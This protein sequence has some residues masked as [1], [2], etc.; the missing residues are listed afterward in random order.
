VEPP[1]PRP[2]RALPK[3]IGR[4]RVVGRLGKGAMAIVYR[5]YDDVMERPVAI[6]VMMADLQDDPE[7]SARFYREAHAAGQLMHRNIITIFDMGED[8]GRPYIV[9]ELLEGQTLGEYVERSDG[10]LLEDK[11][12]L[13]AQVFEGLRPA[14]SK[15]IFHRD[16]KPGNLLVREDGSLKIVD[17][18]IARLMTSSMTVSGLIVG[19]PDYMSPEQACGR[20]VD[21]RSDIFS[22]GAVFYYM[23]TRRKPFAASDLPAVLVKV[24]NEQPLPIRDS[25][26]PPALAKVVMKALEK[27]PAA[28]YQDAGEAI[29]D[30]ARIS[31]G[32]AL[33]AR[34]AEEQ[35][36]SQR[37][38]ASG[39][40][41][42]MFK[43]CG[44]LDIAPNQAD[45]DRFD[46]DIR[47]RHPAYG[48]WL[49][50]QTG[51][52]L[53]HA[54]AHDVLRAVSAMCETLTG[55]V[56]LLRHAVANLERGESTAKAGDL[57]SALSL[58]EATLKEVPSCGRAQDAANRLRSLLAQKRAA[59][60]HARAL[61]IEANDAAGRAE[62]QAVLA[63]TD[64]ALSVDHTNTDAAVLRDRARKAL[65]SQAHDRKHQSEQ[66][67]KRAEKLARKQRYAEAEQAAREARQFDPDS[68]VALE[69]EE[70]F[71]T[72]RLD[73][74]RASAS[75]RRSAEAIAIARRKFD[76]GARTE[77]LSDLR[78]FLEREP[79]S[80]SA[81]AALET[82]TAES[83]RLLA[84]ER[85][86]QQAAEQ[87]KSAEMAL[88][89][90]DPDRALTLAQGAL[91]IDG[92]E[93]LAKNVQRMATAR[94]RERALAAERKAAVDRMIETAKGLLS[95]GQYAAARRE[96]RSAANLLPAE[97]EPLALLALIDGAE[98]KWREQEQREHDARRRANATAPVIAM[99]RAAETTEDF[100]RAGWLAENALAL[101]PDCAEAREIID[102]ARTKVAADPGL[103]DETVTGAE[104]TLI[105]NP[106]L[107]LWHRIFETLRNWL[108]IAMALAARWRGA[109]EP[110]VKQS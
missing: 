27:S 61:L 66:A 71:R 77:A 31:R 13:I 22:A 43:L 91:A 28:R 2:V 94:L 33:E 18:G 15:G 107:P 7:M 83:E 97:A 56:G 11:I 74:E 87:A 62:W 93:P 98:L 75:A 85:R 82:L 103:A 26:A 50:G 88:Q 63:L 40:A 104:N 24:Q 55:E 1:V 12:A 49:N 30:L 80:P 48:D 59:E 19:T 108:T 38:A 84:D 35:A 45:I 67:L 90:G 9:M 99:A 41:D 73:E 39:L 76:N 3:T 51:E 110:R 23:L 79:Q 25:E 17:F 101:D 29:A 86:R 78:A 21:Q 4:Y 106:A 72:A 42:E 105:I 69:L 81:S 70:R 6:K 53:R 46:E 57:A 60:D 16:I 20:E 36:R 32:L 8:D 44:R 109:S 47:K 96:A 92:S 52:P 5:A 54:A 34:H 10:V 14:H 64:E 100:V 95:R 102:R 58:F 65:E 89:S 37:A 68:R